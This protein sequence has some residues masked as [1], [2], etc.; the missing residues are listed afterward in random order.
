MKTRL[1]HIV[2]ILTSGILFSQLNAFGQAA[3]EKSIQSADEI[4]NSLESPETKPLTPNSIKEIKFA[5][6]AE[7]ITTID[8]PSANAM[9][10]ASLQFPI[11]VPQGR[12]G[13]EPQLAVQ[14]NSEG[15]NSW[16][17][18][19][20]GLSTKAVTVETRWGV[21]RYHQTME[22]ETYVLNGE[23][24]SPVAHKA[25]AIARTSEKQ[26][27]PRVE[28][29]FHKIIRHGSNPKN[30]WWEATEK[31][32]TKMFYGGTP[33][34]GVDPT[35]IQKDADGNI[36]CWGITEMRDVHGNFV[37]YHYVTV[38]DPGVT[39]GNPG[40]N[41]YINS[42]T[43]TGSGNTEGKFS[44][45][46]ERDRQLS[47]PKRPDVS[48]SGRWGFKQVTA[49]LLRNIYVKY[50]GQLVRRYSLDYI[51]GAFYK[52][53][54][55]KISEFDASNTLFNVHDFEYYNDVMK[56]GLFKPLA[57]EEAWNPQDD[58]V[59]G[60]FI[61]PDVTTPVGTF[62][63]KASAISGNK[64]TGGGFGTAV[65]F[66]EF[67]GNLSM[68]TNTAGAAFSYSYSV[69]EGILALVDM[70]GDGLMDKVF[71]DK[72]LLY[73][74]LNQSGP[75]GA[76]SFGALQPITGITDFGKG[77][78]TVV[79]AGIESHF[80]IFAGFQYSKSSD[81]T[82]VYLTDVNGDQLIDIVKDGIAYFNH[83]DNLGNPFFNTSSSGT[84][85]P[86]DAG[87]GIDPSL[88][89]VDPQ[90]IENDIDNHPLND[91]V[92]VWQAPYDGTVSITEDVAL[93]EDLSPAAQDDTARDGVRVIIQQNGTELWSTVITENDYTPKTPAN[94]GALSVLKG[95]RIYFRVQSVFNGQYDQV[96]WSP[97]ITY[98]LHNDTIIDP[99]GLDV[100]RFNSGK[101]F[102]IS[103][104]VPISMGIDGAIHIE[105]DF[106]KPVTTDAI[107]FKIIKR[108]GSGVESFI[109]DQVLLW[110][111]AVTIPISYDLN[112]VD[113]DAFYFVVSSQSNINWT[114]LQW[115]PFVYYTVSNNPTVTQVFDSNNNPLIY[116][117]PTVDFRSFNQSLVPSLAWVAPDTN[118]FGIHA[119]PSFLDGPANTIGGYLTFT[120]KKQNELLAKRTALV[121]F[122]GTGAA[123]F[124]FT[125]DTFDFNE[126][127]ELYFEYFT[128]STKLADLMAT[129]NV[130]ITD[131][132]D[133]P[134]N[135]SGGLYT[136][137][138]TFLFGPMY[139]HWGQFGYNG[140]R[141]R[142]SQPI[143]ESELILDDSFNESETIDLSTAVDIADMQD[144]Y[145]NAGG[146]QPKEDKFIYLVPENQHKQW[147]GYDQLTYV[148][149]TVLSSSRLGKDNLY[150]FNPVSAFAPGSPSGAVA[151]SK[152]AKTENYSF[153]ASGTVGSVN[154]G[155]SVSFGNTKFLYDYR[156][157]NGDRYPD[158]LST[159]KIQY[160]LPYGGLESSAISPF[161]GLVGYSNHNSYGVTLGGTFVKSGPTNAKAMPK[162]GKAR[163]AEAD[164]EISGGISG[165][166]NYNTDTTEYGWFDVNG[167]GLPDRVSTKGMV[168][169][170]LGYKFLPPEMWG[171]N[172]PG[173]GD[174]I[175]VGAGLSINISNH[176]I[177]AG[178]GFSKT[179][180]QND[181]SLADM[182]GDGLPDYIESISPLKVRI[183]TGNG[184]ASAVEWTNA[185]KL[186][187][188][189]ST[190]ESA[191]GAFT[192]GIP[193][194]PPFPGAKLCINP[195]FHVSHGASQI[196]I[197]FDD[198]DGDG[199][200]DL[201]QSG[202]DD[203]LSVAHSTIKKTNL[204]KKVNRPLK[205]NFTIDY[206]RIGNTFNMPNSQWSM[207]SVEQFDGVPGDG[208]D[209]VRNAF[210]YE[211]G[212]YDRNE[213]DFYGFE[214]VTALNQNTRNSNAVYRS[215]TNEYFNGNF[216][217]KSLQ[218]STI[219]KNAAGNKFT[220]SINTY[221]L[222]DIHT[223]TILPN[224]FAQSDDGAAFA[225]LTGTSSLY[226]E[227]QATAGKSSSVAYTY[228]VLGNVIAA[229]D[230]GDPGAADD[231]TDSMAY[232]SVPAKYIMNVTSSNIKKSNGQIYRQSATTI[233][234][235]TGKITENRQYL[236]SGDIAKTNYE[237]DAFG[238]VTKMTRPANATG[239]RL[240]YN[241]E[242]DTDVQTY[243]TRTIN[244]YGY[245]SSTT[246]DVRFG[247][248]LS[249][250]NI[251]NQQIQFTLDN[252]GRVKT[253]SGPFEI[254]AGLPFKYSYEYHP[255][256]VVPWALVKH[257]DPANPG[258]L[259][260]VVTFCDGL[261]RQIQTKKDIS[262]FT[263]VLANDVEV[264]QVSGANTYD[265]FGRTDTAY[266]LITEP[267]GTT[268]TI[269][270]LTDNVAP[271][272]V[273]YD[274]LDRIL[275]TKRPD[276]SQS[277]SAYG[278]GPDRNGNNQFRLRE[279]DA[280]GIAMESYTNV[281]KLLVSTKDQHSQGTD[282]LS[283]YEYNPVNELV[284][285][286][287][288]KGNQFLY[289][290]DRMGRKTST[291]HPDAGMTT[292]FYDLNGNPTQIKTA[293]QQSGN[294]IKYTY[295]FE[296]MIKIT[297][298]VNTANNVT[299]TYGAN[300]AAFNRA[301][302]VIK[303]QDA[304]G[305]Q[306]FFFNTLGMLV[307]NIR[308]I[309][310]ADTLPLTLT[311][312]WTYD[313]WNRISV[314]KYPDLELLTYNYN[315]G[316][317][318][319]SMSGVKAGITY[320]YITQKGY[321]K[322][323]KSVYMRY[324]NT[325]DM[326]YGY[327]PNRRRLK[328]LTSKTAANR[329]TMDNTYSY[330]LEENIL[331]I[332][333]SA[334]VPASNLMGGNSNY[335][336]SYD[337]LYRLTNT[338]G[339]F[340]G[341]NHAH[342][343]TLSM[344]YDNTNNIL[345]KNQNHERKGYTDLVWSPRNQTTYNFGY[346]YNPAVKPHAPIHIGTATY[347][348]DANGNQT[349]W[350]DDIS[351]QNRQITWDE[352]NRI[353]TI[354]ENG[355]LFKYIYDGSGQRVAKSAGSSTVIKVNGKPTNKTGSSS[356]N[357]KLYTSPYF[358]VV[359]GSFTKHYFIEGGRIASKY[360]SGGNPP[361]NAENF[362]FFFHSDHLGNSA[363]VTDRLG[364][365]YQHL[366]YFPY[367][368]LFIDEHGNDE[369][370][371]YLYNGKELDQQT[372]LCY[373]GARYYD[374]R[375]SIWE[376]VD[377]LA[378]NAKNVCTSPYSFG[379]A[380][381]ISRI[382]PDGRDWF[383][384]QQQGDKKKTWHWQAG[385]TAKYTNTSGKS[386]VS[387]KGYDYLVT[388]KADR[389][390]YSLAPARNSEGAV[391][392][393]FEVWGDKDPSSGPVVS[394]TAFTGGGSAN[395]N[396][397]ESGNYFLDLRIRDAKGP[398]KLTPKK[399]NPEAAYGIQVIK[400]PIKDG[401]TS[402]KIWEAYGYGRI[403]MRPTDKDLNFV[404]DVHGY[405]IHGKTAPHNYTHG[406]VC[407]KNEQ[408]F[409]YFWEG[410]GSKVRTLVPVSIETN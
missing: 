334:P 407:D 255:E 361:N 311:T 401:N 49:D 54:L 13:M 395:F 111:Q 313:T 347:T 254:A 189:K 247:Q 300:G 344:S 107:E 274:I 76:N 271:T 393:K 408:I 301:G 263:G 403:R 114:A 373:F 356:G 60:D 152:L 113:G 69:N 232:H 133:N 335:L 237:Y 97:Q 209:Y 44:V 59:E 389:D 157:M 183:N 325:T 304:A 291:T 48:I 83:I 372:G 130:L 249:E 161:T 275:T 322:F 366:E 262:L 142:A 374:P 88:V 52:T 267:K 205:G 39:G 297:Y 170:N 148:T 345:N 333:N 217:L 392:G 67:D 75:G 330:D 231:L 281:R 390:A 165:N 298:P 14:Y 128:D 377:P 343:F 96:N 169:L 129:T 307:K 143:N 166:F 118:R 269:N 397:A 331:S 140:N 382:D 386:A 285:V 62:H 112:V 65:T 244:S 195:S 253:M 33:S 227:G 34:G 58:N 30:Y 315:V 394:S 362:Q 5:N 378:N 119:E 329:L 81:L 236:Q 375:T 199:F 56:E 78:T 117:Y 239:Q 84:P 63:D 212:R 93:I 79:E 138:T 320:N 171:M 187:E 410:G 359:S 352:E 71:K 104:P 92:K 278:F 174:A 153:S 101:D 176:S 47:E 303:Q 120:I 328:T 147:L 177:A 124:S 365:V 405:Y 1:L 139:R 31:G 268:G 178:I 277:T 137:D 28:G 106:V 184:F 235:N 257:Y 284:K 132:S 287:D 290:Y 70:N 245:I 283:S 149:K 355:N 203:Q 156:D 41:L 46:F 215:V 116:Y 317:L 85:S 173:S 12:N 319:K 61:T 24:L 45:E 172:D 55:Q 216:Y 202:E 17:G 288:D 94:V 185:S 264:M 292:C 379:G 282:V 295:D 188:S 266:F 349:G 276:L 180:S 135:F 270:T 368:E 103:G 150:P 3:K 261:K 327:E 316:G 348:Y 80:K 194:V 154:G 87:S 370:T 280:N 385:N 90:E 224:V 182:N 159:D 77:K 350:T 167:D 51:T 306:E 339:L 164:A 29:G 248:R 155:G 6:P 357:F 308:V 234:V 158:I 221:V 175:S 332:A 398:Q 207:T 364:E 193:I 353:S 72:E 9:G 242:Y 201:L 396:P 208:A 241:Y 214:K 181:Q 23:Q 233:D 387:K 336:Y 310:S 376:S 98:T 260:E 230:F 99:N 246:Y 57:D 305:T 256:A 346:N 7:E 86:I 251:N 400:D 293:N 294:G 19:G 115:N 323:E 126:G 198:I 225:A 145:A 26:F 21:P 243:R 312:E 406:C 223:G 4:M 73:Y 127:E 144:I 20:W 2:T 11:K 388:F 381:P 210:V 409:D 42:I 95:D 380:N 136:L 341:T 286:V 326:T 404:P 109:H 204:L 66:G 122:D 259:I 252:S 200:P 168:E 383:Y 240:V 197:Q 102:L 371:W 125:A 110:D 74:R 309:L 10:S 218:K 342:R 131:S 226:Y 265:A 151:I 123:I 43:Y 273:T 141:N 219:V 302:K 321:D 279:V 354:T 35:A 192:I 91:I 358:D 191:N 384:F 108:T 64:S 179:T 363:F 190:G 318:L 163:E 16:V 8:A 40:T 196:T 399:D 162:G 82:T 36:A 134:Y 22:T 289:T 27:Y 402:Y 228:D 32:G 206:Q 314:M 324:G 100:Y 50:N 186:T 272:V 340:N 18:L 338:T 369:R 121:S 68:K 38:S 367:G 238:N 211:N 360:V 391:T 222:K 299:L 53:L 89:I 160:T 351:A 25:I 37:K 296:R 105:G 250:T 146:N 220:E 15:G 337:D 229:T 258:N 213:R